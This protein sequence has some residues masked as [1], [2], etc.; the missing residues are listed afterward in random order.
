M[1]THS[2]GRALKLFNTPNL[3]KHSQDQPGVRHASRQIDHK[4]QQALGDAQSRPWATT[5][6]SS[7]RST[8]CWPLRPGGRRHGSL[9]ARA[10][11]NVPALKR[12]LKEPWAACPR[13]RVMAATFPSAATSAICS[14]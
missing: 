7:N 5:S 2:L 10:G 8:C 13:C 14:T 3:G 11:V 4:F 12:D 1:R 9:L 6:S